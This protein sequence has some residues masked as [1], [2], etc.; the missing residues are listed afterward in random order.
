MR[1]YLGNDKVAIYEYTLKLVVHV[2]LRVGVVCFLVFVCGFVVCSW[3]VMC[4]VFTSLCA[5]GAWKFLIV[6]VFCIGF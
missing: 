2:A 6:G 5:G 3:F 4:V 1:C